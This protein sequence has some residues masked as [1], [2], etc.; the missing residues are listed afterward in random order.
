[1]TLSDEVRALHI[2][3]ADETDLL[4]KQWEEFVTGPA[5]DAR[6]PAPEL[7]VVKS[8]YRFVVGPIVR[9]VAD[10]EREFTDRQI[11]VVISELVEKRWYHYLLHNQRAPVLTALL[12]FSGQR[13]TAVVNVP[14][15]LEA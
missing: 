12:M 5:R 13:R 9:Y 4:E 2:D 14:W 6:R 11:A 15:Y 1:M 7:I 10:L 8:P 3:S